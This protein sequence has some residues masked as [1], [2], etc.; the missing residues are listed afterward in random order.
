MNGSYRVYET[1]SAYASPW[2]K[3]ERARLLLWD[4]AW[5]LLCAWT[6][7][8]F[9]PWRLFV[10]RGFGARLSGRPFIHPRARITAPWR[11]TMGDRACLGDGAQA[12]SLGEIVLEERVTIAQ[13]AYLCTGTH[14]FSKP[15]IPLATAPIRVGAGAFVGARAFVLPGTTIGAGAVVGACAVVTR[16]V[17]SGATVAGNPARILKTS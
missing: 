4:A 14:D 12:Y 1:G 8:P 11:L 10:A 17:P 15:E 6:P 13:E 9:N 16:D 3:G 2:T 7:K 5:R